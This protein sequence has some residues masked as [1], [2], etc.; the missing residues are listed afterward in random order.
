MRSLGLSEAM[1]TGVMGSVLRPVSPQCL[2]YLKQLNDELRCT[3]SAVET[4]QMSGKHFAAESRPYFRALH[5]LRCH[6]H[7]DIQLQSLCC[8]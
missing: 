7:L 4:E 8:T 6:R 1:L 2:A 5:H 3:L